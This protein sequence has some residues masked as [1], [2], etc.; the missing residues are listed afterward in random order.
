MLNAF[1]TKLRS[2]KLAAA[3]ICTA[4]LQTSIASSNAA[5]LTTKS[6]TYY[7]FCQMA[8]QPFGMEAL[9]WIALWFLTYS[10]QQGEQ[11]ALN[12]M[13]VILKI[14]IGFVLSPL[15]HKNLWALRSCGL[16]LTWLNISSLP[17][18][19]AMIPWRNL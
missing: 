7:I 11:A 12:I 8:L 19:T 15:R 10:A 3:Q 1:V 18:A 17:A 9:T 14:S 4:S 13:E 16:I 5:K 2:L 6:S